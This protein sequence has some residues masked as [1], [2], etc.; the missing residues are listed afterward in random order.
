LDSRA[1]RLPLVE[2]TEE[3]VAELRADL[4]AAGLL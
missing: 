2:A 1:M 3:Q 4:A